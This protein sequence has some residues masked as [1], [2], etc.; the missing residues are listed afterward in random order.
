MVLITHIESGR[1][2]E[3][4]KRTD[5]CWNMSFKQCGSESV[6]CSIVSKTFERV[7]EFKTQYN[8]MLWWY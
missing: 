1:D 2:W 8:N 7:L 5:S 4:R 3:S 6:L